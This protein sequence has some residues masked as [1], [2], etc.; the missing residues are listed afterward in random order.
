MKMWF[1]INKNIIII[2]AVL[3]LKIAI[4][5]GYNN[6]LSLNFDEKETYTIAEN[7][8]EGKG[9]VIYHEACQC[10]LPTARRGSF[11]I[12][13][14]QFL[15]ENGIALNTWIFCYYCC[16]LSLFLVSVF[17][18]YKICIY[19]GSEKYLSQ[20]ATIIYIL[21][22]SS[23]VYIG[24][25][26]YYENIA[27]SSLVIF[28]Y[29]FVVNNK[30]NFGLPI[31]FIF[32]VFSVLAR[33]HC[34][35]IFFSLAVIIALYNFK[36]STWKS[37]SLLVFCLTFY[38]STEMYKKRNFKYIGKNITSTQTGYALLQGHNPYARGSWM[39]YDFN[40]INHPI[41]QYL[42]KKEPEIFSLNE[43]E[44]DSIITKLSIEWA[45]SNIIKEVEIT[46]RKTAI[47]FLPQ[48]FESQD[49]SRWYNPINLIIHLLY[50]CFILYVIYKRKFTYKFL[51]LLV[52]VFIILGF[53]ILFFVGYRWRYYSEPFM[54]IGAT[55]F[56]YYIINR[57][58]NKQE[59]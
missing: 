5:L 36:I 17:C 58:K 38:F 31:V 2:L 34:L 30:L 7:I 13:L 32:S 37:I 21:Y 33:P 40:T 15:I 56:V 52:P 39:N 26:F 1:G 29:Y 35:L 19:Y 3:L 42:L 45:K 47:F 14:Y 51:L 24:S 9:Q 27:V 57:S 16:Y 4:I 59:V 41:S 53:S 43:F 49:S 44:Q 48:N 6:S 20:I 28:F 22:P 12:A 54:I 55:Y 50:F 25:S 8:I 46:A 11:N 23:L 18:F 10:Y